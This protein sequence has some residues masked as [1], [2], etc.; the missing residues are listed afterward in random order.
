[1]KKI[2]L[3]LVFCMLTI[4]NLIFASIVHVPNV[5]AT[6]AYFT[7]G[8]F[9]TPIT[10][11]VDATDIEFTYTSFEGIKAQNWNSLTGNI[12]TVTPA[13]TYS[14][15]LK[16]YQFNDPIDGSNFLNFDGATAYGPSPIAA[17]QEPAGIHYVGVKTDNNSYAWIMID[18][19]PGVELIIMG[20][21]FEDNGGPIDAGDIGIVPPNSVYDIVSNSTV[22]TTLKVAIDACSLDGTLSGAGPFTLFAPTDAA[23]GLLPTGTVAALLADIPQLTDILL[24]HVVGDSVLSTMLSNNL[25]VS[26]LNG[27]VLVSIT[28]GGVFIES[29]NGTIAQV[30]GADITADNGVVHVIDAVLLPAPPN[31]IYDIVSNST[32]HTTLKA[33]IDACSLDGIL[34][35]VGPF[36]LFAPTDA[37]FNLLPAGTV[38]ALLGDIPQLTDILL[39]HVVGDSVLSTILSN[40]LVVPTLNGDVLVTINS[41][42]V[43]IDNAQVIVA[44]IVADNGVVHVIDA[45]LLPTTTSVSELNHLDKEY[46]YSINILG[47]KINRDLRNQI[48]FDVYIDGSITK[49]YVR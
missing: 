6:V 32:D 3:T 14:D 24:H 46:S 16:L 25:I 44:D 34:S 11:T 10:L 21:A 38:T 30:T 9:P 31:S 8:G 47:E 23:F 26:T 17:G 20:Y 37:A 4:S 43:F 49:R 7:G 28:S 1:M 42:G 39:H 48:I 40:N 12:F 18:V 22:H 35:G 15:G 13:G 45:V 19:V 5:N 2:K 27:D 29:G 36:T 41:M 33:A